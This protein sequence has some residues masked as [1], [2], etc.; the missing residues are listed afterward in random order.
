[1][2]QRYN[3]HTE[4]SR[5]LRKTGIQIKNRVM[6]SARRQKTICC[7]S[8][9]ASKH[10]FCRLA[11]LIARIFDLNSGFARTLFA[12]AQY[13]RYAFWIHVVYFLMQS[14][15]FLLC[16]L[17]LDLQWIALSLR[18]HFPPPLFLL[19]PMS[20]DNSWTRWLTKMII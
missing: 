11:D 6:R 5:S 16:V 20:V 3:V 7:I 14:P 9:D 12:T 10:V 15:S 17:Y 4:G 18:T 19:L 8:L 1:M 13:L 2:N